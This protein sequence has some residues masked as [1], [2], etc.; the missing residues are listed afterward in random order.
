MKRFVIA[1]SIA[2]LAAGF[3]MAAPA[4]PA[5]SASGEKG[6]VLEFVSGKTLVLTLKNG[7]NVAL[8]KDFDVGDPVPAGAVIATGKD[9]KAEFKLVPNGSIIKLMGDTIF[10]LD[11]IATP[12]KPDNAFSLATGKIRTVAARNSKESYTF[13]T[14]TA[15]LGVRGTDFILSVIPGKES[16][17]LVKKGKVSYAKLDAQGRETEEI[18]VEEGQEA[19]SYDEEFEADEYDE[20]EFEEY[21]EDADFEELDV[22]DV[23]EED[24]LEADLESSETEDLESSDSEEGDD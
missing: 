23:P 3:A 22:D 21:Y 18:E 11:S 8:G 9:T 13:T 12:T 4:K 2:A 20:A 10:K 5:A 1:I 24:D 19:D 15:V 6:L 14:Q 16:K 17:V 7:K